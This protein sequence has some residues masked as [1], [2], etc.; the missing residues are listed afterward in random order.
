MFQVAGI[1]MTPIMNDKE[2]NLKRGTQFIRQAAAE[3][4]DL[5]V[6]PE[7]WTTGYYLSKNAF[8]DL[9]EN[10]AGKTIAVMREE[11]V[12]A[13]AAIVC[14]FV[15]KDEK[16]QIYIAA[17]IIDKCGELR[18]VV[19]KSLLWGREQNIF[20]RG[21]IRYPIFDSK[22]GKIGVLICYLKFS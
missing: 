1:Q 13:E 8:Y 12:K 22:V 18:G 16:N 15:E 17:A 10:R 19:R 20:Q 14:P 9:A 3:G 7:L 5:I 21:E 4:V 2:A 6:L 11:A